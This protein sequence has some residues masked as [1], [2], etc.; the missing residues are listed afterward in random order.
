MQH[1]RLSASTIVGSRSVRS[2]FDLLNRSE[3]R[4]GMSEHCGLETSV[5]DW[6]IDHP[7]LEVVF[8]E[9]NI[10]L[11]CAGKSLEYVCRQNGY[12]PHAVLNRLLNS[13]RGGSA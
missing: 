10:E 6:I 7:E 9:L 11:G 13:I 5:P 12:D 4:F 2:I 8:K 3:R 1:Q